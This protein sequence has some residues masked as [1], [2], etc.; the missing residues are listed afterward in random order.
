MLII[1]AD[2]LN[3]TVTTDSSDIKTFFDNNSSRGPGLRHL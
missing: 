3:A 1:E 2:R